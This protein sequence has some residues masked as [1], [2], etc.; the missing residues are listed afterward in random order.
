MTPVHSVL[1]VQQ[2][3]WEKYLIAGYTR[4]YDFD[5]AVANRSLIRDKAGA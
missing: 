5:K 3:F 1:S 4:A 2:Q